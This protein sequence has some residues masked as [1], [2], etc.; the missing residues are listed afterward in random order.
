MNYNQTIEYLYNSLPVFHH[1]GGAAYKPGLENS[2]RLMSLLHNPQNSYKT[3]HVAGT[4]GKG[5]VSHSLAAILQS[6]GYHVGLYTSPHLV[7][8]KE[9]IRVDGEM[10]DEE[11]V[12]DFV[13]ENKQLF[14]EIKPSF[15]ET[16]MAMSFAYFAHCKVDVAVIEVGLGGRLDS[17]NIIAPVLSVI[18]NI[19]YDHTQFLGNTLQ[20]IASEK[21]GI[22]KPYTPVVVGESLPETKLVFIEKAN[23]ENARIVFAED[24]YNVEFIDYEEN[25][26]VFN[27]GDYKMLKLGLK[28]EYQYKN[29]VT[30]LS[31]IDELV[32]AG[33]VIKEDSVRYGLENVVR[34]TGLQGRWQILQN[35]PLTIADTGHNKAGIKFVVNQLKRQKYNKLHVIIGMVNDKDISGV[36]ALL[37]SDAEYYFTNAHIERAL[38]AETLKEE[39][40]KYKLTGN[41]YS[42]VEQA[43]KEASKNAGDEDLIF[44]G[45]SNFVVGEALPLFPK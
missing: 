31:A 9:R 7:D 20:K 21:A 32:H 27:I 26:A 41:I 24:I 18:T 13:E 2:I 42:S 19:S 36:L 10:I 29:V 45:G 3:I 43:V 25:S 8:F 22:I 30:I 34:L 28:G 14:E 12:I 16:T 17:T 35:H 5:S 6:A 15:F 44:I 38:Q 33:F 4:N 1:I 37:P 11:Y 39:A 40:E 23:K